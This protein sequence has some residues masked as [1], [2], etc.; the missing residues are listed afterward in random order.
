V[1]AL[2]QSSDPHPDQL[3]RRPL[4]RAAGPRRAPRG[5]VLGGRR[6]L[7]SRGVTWLRVW[8]CSCLRGAQLVM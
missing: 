5:G 7:F 1:S 8:T 3:L 6:A 4:G 2:A